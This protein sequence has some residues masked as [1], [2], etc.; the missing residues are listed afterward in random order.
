MGVGEATVQLTIRVIAKLL[1]ESRSHANPSRDSW[2]AHLSCSRVGWVLR[3]SP[4]NNQ[5]ESSGPTKNP[6]SDGR[7]G[8]GAV[9]GTHAT[10]SQRTQRSSHLQ[11]RNVLDSQ[12]LAGR[13]AT[14]SHHQ[15]RTLGLSKNCK[16]VC[17]ERLYC[18]ARNGGKIPARD[19]QTLSRRVLA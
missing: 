1:H 9:A 12:C 16:C 15:A 4:P 8:R 13:L 18:L 19:E 2:P 11:V 14:G 5:R 7:R 17:L 3:R 6:T 10:G